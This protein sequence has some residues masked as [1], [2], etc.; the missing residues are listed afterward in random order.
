MQDGCSV[1]CFET[2]C[3][4]FQ[5]FE[6]LKLLADRPVVFYYSKEMQIPGCR[7]GLKR[8]FFLINTCKSEDPCG[9]HGLVTVRFVTFV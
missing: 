8:I 7:K 1:T 4:D 3:R 5:I 6:S 9:C 2:V